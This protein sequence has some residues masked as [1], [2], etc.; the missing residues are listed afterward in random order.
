MSASPTGASGATVG[1]VTARGATVTYAGRAAVADCDLTPPHGTV[2]ALVG[3]NGSGKSTLLSAVAGLAS[4]EAGTVEVLGHRPGSPALSTR[5]AYVLQATP[6]AHHLPLTVREVVTMAR[7]AERGAFGRLTAADRR[8][9][10][11]AMERLEV[12]DIEGEQIRSLSGGQRQRVLVAQGVAHQAE[13]L[14][15]DEPLSGLDFASGARI[16]DALFTMA[17]GGGTVVV[18]THDL[19]EAERCDR[20]LL[21]AGRVVAEGSPEEVLTPA[22]LRAAYGRRLGPQEA[23]SQ[24]ADWHHARSHVEHH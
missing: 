15:L 13:L 22:H 14:L 2:T 7:F 11:E 12:R 3:P 17:R 1:A 24:A 10:D 21:V 16:W 23:D 20:V 4:L 18:A 19:G 6:A 9:V 8:I 5:L